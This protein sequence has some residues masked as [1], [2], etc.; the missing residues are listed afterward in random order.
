VRDLEKAAGTP[1]F[2]FRADEIGPHGGRFH[3]HALI[4][5]VACLR[6]MSWVD[7]SLSLRKRHSANTQSLSAVL[8]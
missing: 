5:N 7:Y 2:W 3:I 8:E 4:G 1:I 6:R